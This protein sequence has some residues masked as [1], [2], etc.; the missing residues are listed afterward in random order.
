[1][2]MSEQASGIIPEGD[3]PRSSIKLR[4]MEAPDWWVHPL[5][6]VRKGASALE[7]AE[8]RQI[9]PV[10]LCGVVTAERTRT[11]ERGNE[12]GKGFRDIAMP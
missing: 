8:S 3:L 5:R 7:Q 12:P 2:S 10:P 11:R 1:M 9:S 4:G 6:K